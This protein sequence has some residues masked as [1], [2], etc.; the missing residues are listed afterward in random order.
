MTQVNVALPVIVC[1]L[2]EILRFVSSARRAEEIAV[3][4]SLGL[5]AEEK[6]P[7][8]LWWWCDGKPWLGSDRDGERAHGERGCRP[9]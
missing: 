1:L 4:A 3:Q 5:S 9:E 2:D 7:D 8:Q 6:L